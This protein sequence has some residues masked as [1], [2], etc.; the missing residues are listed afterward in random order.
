MKK[1]IAILCILFTGSVYADL[2][3]GIQFLDGGPIMP[4]DTL[5]VYLYPLLK[6]A[7]YNIVCDIIDTQHEMHFLPISVLIKSHNMDADESHVDIVLNGG[8][9][10][11]ANAQSKLTNKHNKLVFNGVTQLHGNEHFTVQNLDNNFAIQ[12]SGCLAIPH[13]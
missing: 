2:P 13:A 4:H 8:Y 6:G 12:L 7:R 11:T 10:A 9:I 3:G 5:P 1:W